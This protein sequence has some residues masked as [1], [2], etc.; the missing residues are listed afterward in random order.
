[1]PQN[2]AIQLQAVDLKARVSAP[3]VLQF[4]EANCD[5]YLESRA[6]QLQWLVL[7]RRRAAQ[8]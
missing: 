4:K 2:A 6:C 7:R 5:G 3:L 8:T 1:L